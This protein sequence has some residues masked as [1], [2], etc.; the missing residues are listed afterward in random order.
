MKSGEIDEAVNRRKGSEHSYTFHG[1]DVYAYTAA[2]LASGIIR[3]DQVGPPL[4]QT[5]VSI[6]YQPA[7][8]KG[9]MITGTIPILDIQYGN[10]WTNIPQELFWEL[11]VK[12]GENVQVS[13]FH[14]GKR[15]YQGIMP[16]VTTFGAVPRGKP[17]PISTALCSYPLPLMKA[18][19]QTHTMCHA[20]MNGKW[21]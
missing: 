16:Y 15:I 1:R 11:E 4:P 17:W 19:L 18:V 10:V 9:P 14:K 5:V 12:P 2:R 6:P 13:I 21:K 8:M 3:F 7:D 20:A